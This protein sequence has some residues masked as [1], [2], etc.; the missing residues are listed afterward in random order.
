M[1]LKFI[2]LTLF[3]IYL[4]TITF[5]YIILQMASLAEAHANIKRPYKLFKESSDHQEAYSP[6]IIKVGGG[7]FFYAKIA[8]NIYTNSVF[9]KMYFIISK[10]EYSYRTII[11]LILM[12]FRNYCLYLIGVN[13][14]FLKM[15]KAVINYRNNEKFASYL[16]TRYSNEGDIRKLVFVEGCWKHN[17]L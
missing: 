1:A 4:K 14:F 9:D 15:L 12:Y 7:S 16:M 6:T 11:H 10:K 13:Y 17:P 2:I 8:Y 5:I 3:F